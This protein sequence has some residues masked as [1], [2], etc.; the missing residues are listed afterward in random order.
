MVNKN[1][2]V[3]GQDLILS[4]PFF[5][6]FWDEPIEKNIVAKEAKETNTLDDKYAKISSLQHLYR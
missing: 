5:S 2:I 3:E 6:N 4:A 1:V